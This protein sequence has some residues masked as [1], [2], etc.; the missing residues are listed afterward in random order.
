[1]AATLP[2]VLL[3]EKRNLFASAGRALHDAI[4]PAPRSNILAA[5]LRVG[6]VEDCFLER[7]WLAAHIEIIR[8]LRGFV[9]YII[10]LIW[11]PTLVTNT[12]NFNG[13]TDLEQRCWMGELAE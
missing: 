13:C 7:C 6:E 4:R 2:L 8:I 12:A 1:M 10:T 9:K 11:N 3:C 5:V